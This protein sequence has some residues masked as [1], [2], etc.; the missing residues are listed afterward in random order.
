MAQHKWVD[1]I[2]LT[3]NVLQYINCR[4]V[5][6]G[7]IKEFKVECVISAPLGAPIWRDNDCYQKGFPNTPPVCHWVLNRKSCPQTD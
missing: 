2:V 1:F 6:L 5:F 7:K 4:K 3:Q